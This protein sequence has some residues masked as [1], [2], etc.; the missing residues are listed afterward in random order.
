[1]LNWKYLFDRVYVYTGNVQGVFFRLT[2]LY[3]QLSC[4]FAI[5]VSLF[6]DTKWL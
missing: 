1:M 4:T 3:V 2:N 6:H 5:N